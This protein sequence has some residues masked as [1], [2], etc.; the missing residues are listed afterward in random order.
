[1][2]IGAALN[3]RQL[4]PL[5]YNCEVLSANDTI[6]QDQSSLPYWFMCCQSNGSDIL[7]IVSNN[8]PLT[9]SKE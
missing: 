2:A 9:K 6:L 7:N 5:L 3:K 4:P 8:A 1:M